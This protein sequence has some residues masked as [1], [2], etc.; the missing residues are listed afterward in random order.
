MCFILKKVDIIKMN[1]ELLKKVSCFRYSEI[2][3][4]ENA[5]MKKESSRRI[6]K[7]IL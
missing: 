4:G 3:V 5:R 7:K 2:K 1:E 6:G